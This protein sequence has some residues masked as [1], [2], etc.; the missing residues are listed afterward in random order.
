MIHPDTGLSA[1]AADGGS[2]VVLDNL[3]EEG[4]IWAGGSFDDGISFF[5][6]LTFA[7]D[8][9]GVETAHVHFNDLVGPAYAL[10][11]TVGKFI[12]TI[13]SFGPHSSYLSS[14]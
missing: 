12:P 14:L 4:H 7:S 3:I 9:V 1:G 5:G 2:A 13:S 8:G 6:E 11:L 10:N